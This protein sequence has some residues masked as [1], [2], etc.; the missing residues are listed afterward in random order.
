MDVHALGIDL[1]SA[2]A[3]KIYGPKG[4]GLLY[5]RKGLPL[6]KLHHGG[7]QELSVRAGTENTAG[8]VGFGTAV[9]L[10]IEERAERARHVSA[11]RDRLEK[12]L[13]QSGGIVLGH[14]AERLPGHLNTRF[15]GIDGETLV[16]NLDL[17]NMA[18]STGSA[19]TTG[20]TEPSHVL[21]AMGLSRKEAKGALRLTIGKDNTRTEIDRAAEVIHTLVQRLG[22]ASFSKTAS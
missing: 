17:E 14:P 20:S 5:A 2:S 6:V 22:T 18:A 9:A 7:G 21:L 12:Q 19:C 8:I 1:L 11:L 13:S 4:V 10:A 15:E 16:I 3:H